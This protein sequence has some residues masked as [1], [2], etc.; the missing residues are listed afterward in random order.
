MLP[1]RQSHR[2]GQTNNL[3]FFFIPFKMIKIKWQTLREEKQQINYKL[4]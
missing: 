1:L 4:S 3:M 2:Y